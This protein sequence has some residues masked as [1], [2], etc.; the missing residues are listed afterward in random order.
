[1][2]KVLKDVIKCPNPAC[3]A[4]NDDAHGVCQVCQTPL[5]KRY[6]W[7]VGADLSQL[8]KGTKLNNRYSVVS[9]N[10]V[11][12]SR[13]SAVPQP[14]SQLPKAVLPYLR[15]ASLQ[16][17]VPFPNTFLSPEVLPRELLLQE[18]FL[19]LLEQAPLAR[20]ANGLAPLPT[21]YEKWAAAS[22]LRQV[23]WLRQV[24][25]LWPH[26]HAEGVASTLFHS[27]SLRV[28][29]SWVRLLSLYPDNAEPPTIQFVGH[30]LRQ[31]L[32]GAKPEVYAFLETISN[33]LHSGEISESLVL[34]QQ[35]EEATRT[36]AADLPLKV[37][38][39]AYTDQ[40]PSRQRNEDAC[41]PCS[42]IIRAGGAGS[43]DT[44]P[45]SK[46]LA[47]PALVIVCDGIGGH[48]GG[49][50]A[51]QLAIE[52][53][54]QL[55]E[56]LLGQENLPA[57]AVTEGLQRAILAANDAIYARNNQERRQARSRMGTTVVVGLIYPPFLFVAHVGDSRAYRITAVG[58]NQITLDDDVA[59]RESR[60][61][62]AL[63]RD[64]LQL[65]GA[66]SL[67]QALGIEASD[68]LF[69]TVQH[70]LLDDTSLYLICSDGLSDY[71]LVEALWW[72]ELRPRVALRALGTIGE[73]L[74]NLANTYNGHDN[75]TV[76]L[77]A[78]QARDVKS[79]SSLEAQSLSSSPNTPD[80]G[81]AVL[82]DSEDSGRADPETIK[83]SPV[84][85][86]AVRKSA[87]LSH[88]PWLALL[89]LIGLG[90]VVGVA[91]AWWFGV[92]QAQVR[93]LL[94]L[95]LS[96]FR[97][98]PV[99]WRDPPP[100]EVTIGSY[101]QVRTTIPESVEVLA[102]T[103]NPAASSRSANGA[104]VPAG[105]ILRVLDHLA[106]PDQQIWVRLQIC[107]IPS[108]LSLAEAPQESD[109]SALIPPTI[110]PSLQR[111]AQPGDEGWLL[112]AQFG[113]S[114]R[115]LNSLRPT[116]QGMCSY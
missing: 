106:S 1:M 25:Y 74:I 9:G 50:V 85:S 45:P 34:E 88:K 75:V 22:P 77:I 52:T 115:P 53:I 35:L 86:K 40:G 70:H 92:A 103:S 7:A 107:S 37:S 57:V 24:A 102:L 91:A 19:L 30:W 28:D 76:G 54:R 66:G 42:R 83:V 4:F 5:I 63:Y 51:S 101:W 62:Y 32:P 8:S 69:P 79:F 2:F 112:K 84:S 14:A 82:E 89:T 78:L 15:L 38:I 61:G 16:A 49:N 58:C 87:G 93:P 113:L 26:L 59:A 105:S 11:L 71:D 65:P 95:N 13:P 116:Q 99:A 41:Y 46:P 109:T 98:E 68:H 36:L 108:G 110:S 44:A 10:V 73:R 56:P 20:S 21:L 114:A 90:V 12:D 67:I 55:L 27:D 72:D 39:C 17:H 6:L 104:V 100:L 3:Q 47:S 111:L 97:L 96:R 43:K 60:L 23:N 94:S 18:P 31:F 81:E 48:E 33:Q 80:L 29:E 64:A